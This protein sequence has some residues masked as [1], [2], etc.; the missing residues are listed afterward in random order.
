M[1]SSDFYQAPISSF[2]SITSNSSYSYSSSASVSPSNSG[3]SSIHSSPN[4]PNSN[5]SSPSTK[6]MRKFPSLRKKSSESLDGKHKRN[7]S[8]DL[9]SGKVDSADRKF[10][11]LFGLPTSEVLIQEHAC[12]LHPHG[13]FK[14]HGTV[15]ISSN[16]ICFFAKVFGKQTKVI[17][18]VDQINTSMVKKKCS[19]I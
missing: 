13:L 11:S 4:S 3:S 18:D 10:L 12:Y 19:S 16:Y 6:N 8:S 5:T 17:M 7:N 1:S 9:E 14:E 2:A 15:Y